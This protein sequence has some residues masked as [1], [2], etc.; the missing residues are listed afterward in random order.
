LQPL[1]EN[2]IYHGIEQLPAGGEISVTGTLR[3]KRL[4]IEITNPRPA[5]ASRSAGHRM[6]LENIRQRFQLAYSGDA[7]LDI[8]ESDD[9]YC[10]TLSFPFE[11]RDS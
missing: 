5:R 7:K 2:A 8:D 3:E 1:L 4:R 6:A 9:A 11:T 10:V